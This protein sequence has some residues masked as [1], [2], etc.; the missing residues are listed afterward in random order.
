MRQTIQARRTTLEP[1]SEL[2]PADTG[3]EIF[4]LLG[5]R[6]SFQLDPGFKASEA[7]RCAQMKLVV[8]T[9]RSSN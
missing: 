4:A 6:G 8:D 3:D 1:F 9:A 5:F 2:R 7:V